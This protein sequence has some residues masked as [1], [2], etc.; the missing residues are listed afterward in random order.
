[1]LVE[2]DFLRQAHADRGEPGR[3]GGDAF[4]AKSFQ[5]GFAAGT[6]GVHA[7]IER[8]SCLQPLRKGKNLAVIEPDPQTLDYPV[9]KVG[10]DFEWQR[11][12]LDAFEDGEPFLVIIP[13]NWGEL[14]ER[15]AIQLDERSQRHSPRH[16]VRYQMLKQAAP[17]QDSVDRFS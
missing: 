11:F 7:Q 10:A 9:R 2:R 4:C 12:S 15:Q 6:E 5:N 8:G 14:L 16:A 3:F 17:T 1:M 13:H